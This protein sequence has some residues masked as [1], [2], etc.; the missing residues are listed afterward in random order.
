MDKPFILF[1]T[2]EILTQSGQEVSVKAKL[3]P[4]A[5]GDYN[6]KL[7]KSSPNCSFI[8]TPGGAKGQSITKTLSAANTNPKLVTFKFKINCSAD[9]KAGF[10][11]YV[12]ATDK[13]NVNSNKS[14]CGILVNF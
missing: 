5:V 8:E 12:V 1:Q 9:F 2:H 4:N 14:S 6:I 7:T 10:L 3:Y 11:L 13:N